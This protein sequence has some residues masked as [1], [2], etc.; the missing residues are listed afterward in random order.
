MHLC[1][2]TLNA[3]HPLL[4][5][6]GS[7]RRY[8][9]IFLIT[10]A[11]QVPE[12]LCQSM[13]WINWKFYEVCGHLKW[14]S[15]VKSQYTLS[16]CQHVPPYIRFEG[17]V[18]LCSWHWL[19]VTVRQRDKRKGSILHHCVRTAF[20][21]LHLIFFKAQCTHA[22]FVCARA[23]RCVCVCVCMSMC[24]VLIIVLLI[25]GCIYLYITF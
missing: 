17:V 7:P 16:Q 6:T 18:E 24:V 13:D 19:V 2:H 8:F 4:H 14:F 21:E 9:F 3:P 5:P 15:S 1:W 12:L 10:T 23:R 25:R 11:S 22:A 20:C